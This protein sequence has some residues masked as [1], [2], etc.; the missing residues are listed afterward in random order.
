[1]ARGAVDG[2]GRMS[3]RR[4]IEVHRRNLGEI[5]EIMNS[6]KSLAYI[7]TRKLTKRLAAQRAVVASI[8]TAARDFLSFFPGAAVPRSGSESIRL[9]VGTERGFCGDLNQLLWRHAT[10][11]AQKETPE[12]LV[13]VGRK[14]HGLFEDDSRVAAFVDGAETAEEVASVLIRVVAEL[15]ALQA[16]H[17]VSTVSLTY[18]GAEHEPK[19]V[20]L[21]P[22]FADEALS[23][24][25]AYPPVLNLPA[26]EFLLALTDQYLFAALNEILYSALMEE[27]H[28]RV[29]HLDGAVN[30][31]D[32]QMERLGR[33][34][35][36]LRQEEIIEEIEIILLS[37]VSS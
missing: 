24:E 7:E 16:R 18:L 12:R 26:P 4:N 37:A 20:R 29:T 2:G 30:H 31:L 36:E 1:L 27:N 25:F 19:T 35:N 8:E 21:L 3:R 10:A 9:V 22:S 14:L 17:G 6:M 33:R 11:A 15:S 5:R 28:R 13:V 34:L 32:E 23:Q